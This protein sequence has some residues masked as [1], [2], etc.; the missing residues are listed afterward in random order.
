[1]GFHMLW[2]R[3]S[4]GR[5][6]GDACRERAQRGPLGGGGFKSLRSTMAGHG[7]PP[8]QGMVL[9]EVTLPR[10]GGLG[11]FSNG[12][13]QRIVERGARTF[14][15]WRMMAQSSPLMQ[16]VARRG[17]SRVELAQVLDVPGVGDR[18]AVLRLEPCR[19]R[20]GDVH[21]SVGQIGRASCRE[22]VYVL[23]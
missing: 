16:K 8:R 7:D 9:E 14:S 3:L 2:L 6:R 4:W 12:P 17:R 1:M 23:V 22:R 5:A 11:V 15:S 10:V 19:A 18:D 13:R 21:N 20:P